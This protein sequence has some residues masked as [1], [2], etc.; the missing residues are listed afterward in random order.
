VASAS[1]VTAQAKPLS[2]ILFECLFVFLSFSLVWKFLPDVTKE[3]FLL[4]CRITD[5]LS[6]LFK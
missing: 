5:S 6:V 3:T 1:Y 4:A 2:E